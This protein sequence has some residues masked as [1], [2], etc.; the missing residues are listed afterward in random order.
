[1]AASW[2]ATDRSHEPVSV[3]DAP[4]KRP[5]G[6]ASR[7]AGTDC[8]TGLGAG[9]GAGAGAGVPPPAQR[10]SSCGP[11]AR[12]SRLV[13]SV[14]PAVGTVTAR[15]TTPLPWTARL[16]SNVDH[17]PAVVRGTLATTSRRYPGR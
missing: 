2:A 7:A 13:N 1:M 8:G 16:T 14:S 3:T 4:H 5:D 10:T 11:L 6:G 15:V 17:R 12:A 9:A